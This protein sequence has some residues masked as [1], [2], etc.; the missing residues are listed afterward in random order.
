VSALD[1]PTGAE[2]A[3]TPEAEALRG[4]IARRGGP[5]EEDGIP[6]TGWRLLAEGPYGYFFGAGGPP[7]M[8]MVTI[9][10]EDGELD[11]G[12]AGQC[13][14]RRYREGFEVARWTLHEVPRLDATELVVDV[15]ESSCASGEAPGDRL[16]PAEVV[17]NEE[18]VTLTFW[19]KPL[20]GAQDCPGNPP[21]VQTVH[22][23]A[24]LDQRAL[25]DGAFYPGREVRRDESSSGSSTTVVSATTVA[26]PTTVAEGEPPADPD[27]ARAAIDAAFH[28]AFDAGI[29]DEQRF[30]AVE[31]GPELLAAGRRAAAKFPEAAASIS[32]TVHRITFIDPTRAAVNFE[33]LYE[34]A[35]LL[36]PQDGEAVFLDGH[37][38][39]SRATRCAI[40]EQAGVSCP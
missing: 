28:T 22:L 25:L 26:P 1:G 8:A 34:G 33:L 20:G 9:W 17:E 24:P 3:T 16:Q 2:N 5:P 23:D 39:V 18:S 12:P 21:T 6:A 27:A 40:I 15:S 14:T 4:V 36:G 37:W 38:K 31:D 32:A 35:M 29:P 7:R 30:A 19:I 13:V 10:I 11:A